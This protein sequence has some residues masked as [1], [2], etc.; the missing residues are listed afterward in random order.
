MNRLLKNLFGSP[1]SGSRNRSGSRKRSYRPQ[2]D[3]LEE[4][5]V[6]ATF[7]VWNPADSGAG[8]LREAILD[9]NA[10]NNQN[11]VNDIEFAL[12]PG[13]YNVINLQ[14]RLPVITAPV[15]N[16]G[17]SQLG[18]KENTLV[19]GDNA[20]TSIFLYGGG[21]Y[22][23][24]YV[25]APHV[26]V[27]GLAIAN[28]KG[29][30][31]LVFGGAHDTVIQGNW[32]GQNGGDGIRLWSSSN[33]IG[34]ELDLGHRNVI[35]GN[36]GWGIEIQPGF[37]VIPHGNYIQDNWIGLDST[38]LANGNSMG[39]INLNGAFGTMIGG[40]ANAW[41]G[42]VIA[43]NLGSGIVMT[44]AGTSGTEVLGNDIH[45]NYGDGV[46]IVY[47]ASLNF[48]GAHLSSGNKIHNNTFEGV[49]LWGGTQ[50]WATDN[51]IFA[52]Q[53]GIGLMMGANQGIQAP[54]LTSAVGGP[55]NVT[56]TG[57]FHGKPNTTYE[58]E[59][60]DNPNLDYYRNEGMTSL[61]AISVTTDAQGN[62]TFVANLPKSVQA[63]H[64]ITAQLDGT[65]GSSELSNYVTFVK[66]Q[67]PAPPPQ[68]WWQVGVGPADGGG[69]VLGPAQRLTDAVF[70]TLQA[71]LDG[72]KPDTTHRYAATV[73]RLD[74]V[75]DAVW[76]DFAA[77]GH[78]RKMELLW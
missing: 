1:S 4:R 14:S 2:I 62:A 65:E 49:L 18:S 3:A 13:A 78:G 58:L 52:N 67:Q 75:L 8:T 69:L 21:A 30:G 76:A 74:T 9:S 6:P 47:G 26:T 29:D 66:N 41:A 48:V 25:G 45:H 17:Y 31:I 54:L 38:G 73:G 33:V 40:N 57:S 7:T 28:F 34:G 10:L 59:F 16:D 51:S 61:G 46:D 71:Q 72:T 50:N 77:P 27:K 63:G 64:T 15:N 39:G 53:W 19:N 44:G 60:Y 22:T 55:S 12:T 68:P 36:K 43:Y 23:G 37:G 32:I 5:Q 35:V 42:N 70:R 56:I 11:G 24:L 20:F